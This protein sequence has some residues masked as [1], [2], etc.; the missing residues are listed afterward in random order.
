MQ[1]S[2]TRTQTNRKN[3]RQG[4]LYIRSLGSAYNKCAKQFRNIETSLQKIECQ[5]KL[6]RNKKLTETECNEQKNE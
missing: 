2:Y 5:P 1:F 6:Q 4:P 3:P